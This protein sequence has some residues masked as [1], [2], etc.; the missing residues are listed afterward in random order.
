MGNSCS[1]ESNEPD[2]TQ[3]GTKGNQDGIPLCCSITSKRPGKN[4]ELMNIERKKA[5][6]LSL[7]RAAEHGILHEIE[8]NVKQWT[9]SPEMIN[10]TDPNGDTALHKAARHDHLEICKIL[11]KVCKPF[12]QK[13]IHTCYLQGILRTSTELASRF[14]TRLL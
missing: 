9:S 13:T 14:G 11:C 7:H 12:S 10:S 2:D 6:S 1:N 8:P 5:A 4:A 3:T